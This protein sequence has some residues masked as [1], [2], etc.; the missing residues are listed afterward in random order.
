[1][2]CRDL[3]ALGSKS[4]PQQASLEAAGGGA[5]RPAVAGVGTLD[6]LV[7]DHQGG[8][9]ML[10]SDP[11]R[12]AATVAARRMGRRD[13]GALRQERGEPDP[14]GPQQADW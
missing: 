13:D 7:D 6:E 3:Q 4:D 12:N 14:E 1:M 2:R 8:D 11:I 9:D 5:C 10:E